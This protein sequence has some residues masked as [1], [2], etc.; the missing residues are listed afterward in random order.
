MARALGVAFAFAFAALLAFGAHA[1]ETQSVRRIELTTGARGAFPPADALW[2]SHR[3][4]MRWSSS[5]DRS[6]IWLRYSFP[7]QATPQEGWSI[8]FGRLA[9]GGTVYL[10]GK[11]VAAIPLDSETRHVHWRRPH[12][13]NLPNEYLRAGEN[14]VTVYT[15]YGTG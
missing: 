5:S 3:L 11:M 2:Q 4:P 14:Q 7:L 8:L 13:V 9:N 6:G 1:D 12:L 10:N 15:S